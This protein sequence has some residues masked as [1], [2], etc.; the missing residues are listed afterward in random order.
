[1]LLKFTTYLLISGLASKLFAFLIISVP[2]D[3]SIQHLVI[4]ITSS[5]KFLADVY[6]GTNI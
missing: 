1:M 4:A 3:I 5:I 6:P 2:I